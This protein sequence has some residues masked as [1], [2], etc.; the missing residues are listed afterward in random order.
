[1]LACW[2]ICVLQEIEEDIKIRM[3]SSM[4]NYSDA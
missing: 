1:M 4:I 3:G 2:N